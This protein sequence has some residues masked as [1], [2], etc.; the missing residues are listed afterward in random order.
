MIELSI[1]AGCSCSVWKTEGGLQPRIE[2]IGIPTEFSI[3]LD[4][5]INKCS[6]EHW[7]PSY[8]GRKELDAEGRAL[9]GELQHA[10]GD[11][12][13]VNFRHWVAFD[14]KQWRTLWREELIPTGE[15]KEFWLEDDLPDDVAVKVVKIFPD[16]GGAY[17]WDLDGVCIGNENPAFSDDLDK[18]FTAWSESWDV[19][20]NDKT[21]K[22]DKVRLASKRFDERGLALAVELKR[23]I[24]NQARVIYCCQ[25]SEPA[26]EVLED[27]STIEWPSDT[28]FRQWALNS[29][30]E[31][32]ARKLA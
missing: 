13:A 11:K 32:I 26:V 18:R 4:D 8:S 10:V 14:P 16:C 27:G 25:L 30:A 7:A 6:P 24:R 20:F 2:E 23:A 17:L 1:S 29:V 21:V 5:W 22:V 28:D 19:C 12:F 31:E 9:A 3:R 15:C